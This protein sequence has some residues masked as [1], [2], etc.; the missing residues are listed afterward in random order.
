MKTDDIYKDIAED[1]ERRFDTSNFEMDRPIPK[2]KNKKVLGLMKGE[3]GGKIIKEFVG[4]RA[5]TYSY[6]R[7]NIDEDRKVKG[8]KTCVIKRKLQFEYYKNCL[9]VARIVN[10]ID[11]LEKNNEMIKVKDKFFLLKKLTRLL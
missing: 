1:V 9:E 2:E 6:L 10:K 3:L 4:L 8:T 11:P 5:K 7:D